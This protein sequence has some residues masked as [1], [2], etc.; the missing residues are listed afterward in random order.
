VKASCVDCRGIALWQFWEPLVCFR[1]A[2]MKICLA[3]PC[4]PLG[5]STVTVSPNPFFGA[6]DVT[7][8]I[9]SAGDRFGA[10]VSYAGDLNGDGFSD[11]IVGAQGTMPEA[12]T[13]VVHIS[14]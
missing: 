3:A 10:S 9:P 4:H 12:P 13:L 14:T 6:A 5:T 1:L 8:S 11:L 2:Y 7:L